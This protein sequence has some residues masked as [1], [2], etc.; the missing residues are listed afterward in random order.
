[1]TLSGRSMSQETRLDATE[2]LLEVQNLSVEF[3]T[4]HDSLIAVDGVSFDVAPGE[5]LGR[6]R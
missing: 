3:P 4:R 2:P 5:I 1:M 6:G